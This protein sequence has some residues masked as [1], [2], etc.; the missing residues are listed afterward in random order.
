M[1][2]FKQKVS[3]AKLRDFFC[4]SAR[5]GNIKFGS[6]CQFSSAGT[7]FFCTLPGIV[8]HRRRQLKR[9]CQ[10]NYDR[11]HAVSPGAKNNVVNLETLLTFSPASSALKTPR[12]LPVRRMVIDMWTTSMQL[13]KNFIIFLVPFSPL[14][15]YLTVLKI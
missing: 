7:I 2:L 12:M 8:P 10:Y 1:L 4:N 6:R 3:N 9:F 14:D 13:F 5:N 15:L 11:E